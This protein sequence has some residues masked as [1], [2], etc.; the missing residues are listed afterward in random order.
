MPE[1]VTTWTAENLRQ[2][3][4]RPGERDDKREL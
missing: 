4:K 2:E 3:W 1:T